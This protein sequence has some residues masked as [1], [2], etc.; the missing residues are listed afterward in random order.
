VCRPEHV[1][2][3]RNTGIINYTTQLHL[4]GSLYEIQITGY[5][6][7]LQLLWLSSVVVTDDVEMNS[8]SPNRGVQKCSLC[9]YCP[10]GAIRIT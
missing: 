2:Q 4:V 5:L 10:R 6:T 3:L 9:E 1:E 7:L 8:A